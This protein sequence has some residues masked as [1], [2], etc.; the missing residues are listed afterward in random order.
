MAKGSVPSVIF[1]NSLSLITWSARITFF[2]NQIVSIRV[3]T[4]YLTGFHFYEYLKIDARVAEKLEV[5][6]GWAQAVLS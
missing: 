3:F 6:L 2:K 1:P 5:A 4:I